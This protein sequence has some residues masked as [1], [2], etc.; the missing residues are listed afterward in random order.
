MGIKYQK[1]AIVMGAISLSLS[2]VKA[3]SAQASEVAWGI[4]FFNAAG[5]QVGSGEFSYDPGTTTFVQT[6]PDIPSPL[7]PSGFNVHTALK[8][9]AATILGNQWSLP[10]A[11]VGVTWLDPSSGLEQQRFGKSPQP[12]LADSWFF[13][14]AFAGT[15]QLLLDGQAAESGGWGGSW[16]QSIA[17]GSSNESGSWV[18][19]LQPQSEGVPE[20]TTVLGAVT[21]GAGCLLRKKMASKKMAST[22]K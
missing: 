8:S 13:G 9:F 10:S 18:A 19:A 20:P 11:G 3:N 14:D 2:V 5:T 16:I 4:S 21:F 15:K 12:F 17:S 7:P 22:K 6:S 1:M